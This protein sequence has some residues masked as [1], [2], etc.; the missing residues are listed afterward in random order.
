MPSLVIGPANGPISGPASGRAKRAPVGLTFGAVAT[1]LALVM[2]PPGPGLAQAAP[3]SAP[4]ESEQPPAPRPEDHNT[5]EADMSGSDM[6]EDGADAATAT[7]ATIEP[8]SGLAGAYLAA[9]QAVDSSDFTS[10][11]DWF[12]KALDA[13]PH[14]TFLIDSA[15]VSLIS[16]G[17]VDRAAELAKDLAA[18]NDATE[19][20][21]VVLRAADAKAGDWDGLI[22]RID[23][24]HPDRGDSTGNDLLDGMLHAWA[25]LG[26]GR[27][28]DAMAQMQKLA[29]IPGAR[30][31]VN[32]DLALVKASVG[33]YEGA[34]ELLSQRGTGEHLL[35]TIAHAEVLAQLDRRDDALALLTDHPAAGAEPALTELTAKLT[36]GQPVPFTGLKD[37][38]DGVAQTFLTFA[39]ALSAGDE[40][41]PLALVQARLAE[42]LRPDLADA[43]LV[44]AQLLQTVG[45]FDL[46]EEEY[47][48]LRE[49]G[50]V[51][52]IAELARIDALSR[53]ERLEDAEKAART[54]TEAQPELSSGWIALGDILRQ[55]EKFADSIP[56]YSKGLDLI[57]KDD[58]EARWF[59]LYARG[60]ARE[61]SGDFAGAESDMRAALEIRPDQAS[62]LNYLG[63]SFIDRGMNLEEGLEMVKKAAELQP[64]DG[65]IQ[66]SLGWGLYRIGRYEDA[67][68]PMEKAATRMSS[69]P[70]VNDHLGDVYW[71][72]GRKREAEVQWRRA[73]SLVL[74][75]SIHE[76]DEEVDPDLLRAKIEYGLD[77]VEKDGDNLR[78]KSARD[79]VRRGADSATGEKTDDKKA[80]GE[81][82][83]DDKSGNPDAEGDSAAP[84]GTEPDDSPEEKPAQG[85]K[86]DTGA[87]P[88][89]DAPAKG[90]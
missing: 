42:W 89:A 59:P 80:S 1:V 36:S 17:E 29:R 28:S 13:D 3:T 23:E 15:L 69:D 74:D 26:A 65:Y 64:E 72:N 10:A 63:Y 14:E 81:A 19:L 43:R 4:A 77:A 12:L 45:Q 53:A 18:R 66:D 22:T 50:E 48:A 6:P 33:D 57:S 87:D 54:L 35:G 78:A 8:I 37:A 32:Y 41:D 68:V 21:G 84:A 11:A 88:G 76:T 55:S 47:K 60:I 34:E 73:L 52:P 83:G 82:D 62:I 75:D 2:A 5:S 38:L 85:G 25:E 67:V 44:S 20:A 16:A 9:R 49:Q 71:K 30:M 56:A 70:L 61:R 79:A 39:S 24:G 27:A 31:M 58:G 7:P 90:D 40:P 51:R 86:G 46:A